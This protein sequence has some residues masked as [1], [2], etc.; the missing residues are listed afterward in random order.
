MKDREPDS[1][2]TKKMRDETDNK[3]STIEPDDEESYPEPES[4][5][6]EPVQGNVSNDTLGRNSPG[7]HKKDNLPGTHLDQEV[8]PPASAENPNPSEPPVASTPP[9]H[10]SVGGLRFGNVASQALIIS[11]SFASAFCRAIIPI[12]KGRPLRSRYPRGMVHTG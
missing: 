9:Y 8:L 12:P 5:N 11:K 4:S 1:E 3:A 6:S 10:Y 2:K 7:V